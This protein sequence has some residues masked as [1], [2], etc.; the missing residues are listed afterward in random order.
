VD[1]FPGGVYVDTAGL[2]KR[3]EVREAAALSSIRQAARRDSGN[4]NARQSSRLR[5]VSLTRLE[6]EL[7]R[8]WALGQQPTEV[9]LRFAGLQKIQYVFVYPDSRD[10]VLAGPAGDWILDNEGRCVSTDSG[11]P[12]LH[13][14]DFAVLLRNAAEAGGRFTCSITPTRE[15]LAAAQDYLNE[16]S[17][18]P[19]RPGERHAWLDRLRDK[20]GQQVIEV[21]G[22]DPRTRVARVIVEADYRMKLVGMGI[23]DGVLGVKSYL[24][25]IPASDAPPAMSVLRWWFTMNYGAI[26]A[27]PS[28]NAYE[29]RGQGV[30]VLS[31]NEMLTERGERVPTGQSDELNAQFAHSFTKH[32]D[33]LAAKYPIYAELQ[34]V[35]DLALVAALLFAED[36]PGQVG[37]NLVHFSDAERF[38]VELGA[39][40]RFV[41]TVANQRLIRQKHI[42]AGVSGGVS[43][44]SSHF[45]AKPAIQIDDYGTLRAERTAAIPRDLP[46]EAWWWD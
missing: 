8:R 35:F 6:R 31:E 15:N 14:D 18:S 2:M 4:Q 38:Q 45:V 13:L 20:L 46:P 34:N 21:D 5:M 27:T 32:F 22:I 19:L 42:V 44:N 28:R 3:I 17:K 26:Q 40:P 39:A 11:R 29:I 23:E 9:M 43:V 7:Q 12:V 1:G 41:Q 24:D 37:W 10:I 30:K 16:T 25:A 33:A 36:L